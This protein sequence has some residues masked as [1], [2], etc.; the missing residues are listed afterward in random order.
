MNDAIRL[1]PAI[2][3]SQPPTASFPLSARVTLSLT[4]S[5]LHSASLLFNDVHVKTV[6][7]IT[8]WA[9][10]EELSAISFV[11]YLLRKCL[12]IFY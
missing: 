12:A 6:K 3:R 4:G 8:V 9:S 1:Q 2:H 7:I 10:N 5:L 11:V